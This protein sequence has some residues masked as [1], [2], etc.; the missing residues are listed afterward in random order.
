VGV[1][2]EDDVLVLEVVEPVEEP[3]VEEVELVEVED[4]EVDEVEVDDP[5]EVVEDSAINKL[6]PAALA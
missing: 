5:V 1:P 3:E 6:L 4:V 2:E